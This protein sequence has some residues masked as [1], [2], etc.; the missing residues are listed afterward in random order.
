MLK[1]F[2][3]T[4]CAAYQSTDLVYGY[5]GANECVCMVGI[6]NILFIYLSLYIYLSTFLCVTVE[7]FV[8]TTVAPSLSQVKKGS[9]WDT[10][11]MV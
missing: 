3:Y 2:Y 10:K 1:I 9:L 5:E 6:I 8:P 7:R 11:V 4:I